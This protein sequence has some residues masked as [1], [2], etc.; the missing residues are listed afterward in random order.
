MFVYGGLLVRRWLSI[1]G[2]GALGNGF[3]GD[4]LGITVARGLSR[5]RGGMEWNDY[6]PREYVNR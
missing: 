3:G 5:V 1:H 6:K 2:Y 4:K